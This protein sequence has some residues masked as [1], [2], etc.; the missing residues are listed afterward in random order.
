M[1]KSR[2]INWRVREKR[3]HGW[4]GVCVKCPQ[5]WRYYLWCSC[6]SVYLYAILREK[7]ET[8]LRPLQPR[9]LQAE[10][11][12]PYNCSLYCK[13]REK[14]F[15]RARL[16]LERRFHRVYADVLTYSDAMR[17]KERKKERKM[18]PYL[19]YGIYLFAYC[20]AE[21]SFACYYSPW[22]MWLVEGLTM[23]TSHRVHKNKKKSTGIE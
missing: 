16:N 6:G 14:N 23:H 19:D 3:N 20:F 18:S 7:W 17:K 8:R 13:A 10:T 4:I 15:C 12:L 5:K 9:F 22:R 21:C 11:N 2:D 1:D